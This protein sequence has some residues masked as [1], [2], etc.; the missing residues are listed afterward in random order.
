LA[1]RPRDQPLQLR[2]K[3]RREKQ[4]P[5]SRKQIALVETFEDQA[6]I[7]MENTRLFEE[8]QAADRGSGAAD[9]KL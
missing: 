8:V 7:A 5:Y 6:V 2:V 1:A 4:Q 3:Y 9:S